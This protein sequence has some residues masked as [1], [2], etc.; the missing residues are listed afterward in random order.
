MDKVRLKIS[1]GEVIDFFPEILPRLY[2]KKLTMN[3]RNQ[4]I[5]LD[6]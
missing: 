2:K 1:S 4:A 3:S 5:A 6:Y